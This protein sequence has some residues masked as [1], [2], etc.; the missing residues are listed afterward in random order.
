MQNSLA[1][2]KRN[3]EAWHRQDS[4]MFEGLLRTVEENFV[5][6]ALLVF[7]RYTNR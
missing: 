2:W 6:I 7:Q 4:A 1:K 3:A 5:R